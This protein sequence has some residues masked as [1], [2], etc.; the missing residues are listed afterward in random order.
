[1]PG[2]ERRKGVVKSMKESIKQLWRDDRPFKK[3]L[4]LSALVGLALPF[5]FVTV[6]ILELFMNNI[7]LFPF[8]IS[9]LLTPTLLLSLLCFV[10]LTA[11]G[12]L[13]KGWFLDIYL[14]LEAGFLLA[15]YLQGNFLNLNLGEMTGDPIDW[16]QYTGHGIFNT[17][18]WM[19]LFLAPLIV[20]TFWDKI[21]RKL[22]VI[23]PAVLIAMQT[24]GLVSTTLGTDFSTEVTNTASEPVEAYLSEKGMFELS[25]KKNVLV[26]VLDRLDGKYIDQVQADDATF[27]DDLEGFTYYP[28]HTSLYGRTY[29]SVVYLLTGKVSMFDQKPEELFSTA[30]SE[31]RFIPTLREHGFT[32]KLY[33]GKYF[34]YSDISQLEGLA[35]NIVNE[36]METTIDRTVMLEKMLN[37]SAYRYAP[38]VMKQYFWFTPET[39]QEAVTVKNELLPFDTEEYKFGDRLRA[40]PLTLQDQQD[41]FMYLHIK[42]CHASYDMDENGYYVEDGTSTLLAQTKGNFRL[43]KQYMQQMKDLGVYDSSTIIITG[44]HGKSEDVHSLDTYKTTALFVKPSGSPREPLKVSNKPVSHANFQATVLEAAGIETTEFGDSIWDVPEDAQIPRRFLYRMDGGEESVLEEYQVIGDARNF[45]NWTYVRDHE[46]LYN[47]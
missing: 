15:G 16:S 27:F 28:N 46:I 10:I 17:L 8:T 20:F 43:L 2:K 38:H 35:D 7:G 22:I 19:V 9:D 11:V 26:F 21:W 5:T 33:L 36:K 39:F 25:T 14:S 31:G 23:L 41:N 24:A 45:N 32:T 29:P 13:L 12:G 42:G 40:T 18:V 37:F 1:M 6:G 30:Y 3:R 47:R 34:T 44:D 4:A